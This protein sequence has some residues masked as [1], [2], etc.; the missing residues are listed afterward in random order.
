[1]DFDENRYIGVFEVAKQYFAIGLSK[2]KMADPIWRLKIR[3]KLRLGSKLVCG[4]FKVAHHDL[5]ISRSTFKMAV[6]SSKEDF[7]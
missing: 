3:R 2:Y 6:K 7:A 1:M 4:I 5:A